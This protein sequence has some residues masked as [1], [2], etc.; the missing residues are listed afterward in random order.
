MKNVWIWTLALLLAAT[1]ARAQQG[2]ELGVRSGITFPTLAPH[3]T[4]TP[5]SKGYASRSSWGT[6]IFGEYR[7][8]DRFSL[9]VGLEYGRLGAQKLGMQAWNLKLTAE[10]T[11]VADQVMRDVFPDGPLYGRWDNRITFDC[12]TLPVQARIGWNLSPTSPWR[13]YAGAGLFV[14]YFVNAEQV[15]TG[16]SNVYA[17]PNGLTLTEYITPK[18]DEY[19]S[20][21]TESERKEILQSYNYLDWLKLAIDF[22]ST[23]KEVDSRRDLVEGLHPFTFGVIGHVGVSY[24]FCGRHKVFVEGGGH[25]G[26]GN[27]QKEAPNGANRIA[28]ASVMLGYSFALGQ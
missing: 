25:Y 16:E 19:A 21:L 17:D 24:R 7:F 22:D 10:G 28:G 9:T 14:S 11:D 23:T 8:D 13:L 3:G 4:A 26:L 15:V 27:I 1:G 18:L 2:L 20:I 5:L 6:G 12:L